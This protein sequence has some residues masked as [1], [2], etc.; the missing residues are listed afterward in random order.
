MRTG[1]WM[2]L[3]ISAAATAMLAAPSSALA[4]RYASP[5]GL[6]TNDCQSPA[7]A[8]DL[9]TAIAGDGGTNTPSAGE[10]VIVQPGSYTNDATLL[11]GAPNMYIHGDF[12]GQRPVINEPTIG[13][14]QISSGTVSYLDF[15]SGGSNAVNLNGGVMERVLMKGAGNGNL[16]CQCY[17]GILRDSV[18]VS[19][20]PSGAL[21]VVSNGGT[22]VGTY[23]NVT[24]VTTN[25]AAPAILI[26][27]GGTPNALTFD[28]Y[29][30][31]ASNLAGGT[32]VEAL[33]NGAQLTL[34]HSNYLRPVQMSSGVVQDAPG[35]P[36]QSTPPLFTNAAA[37][38]FSEALGSPTI[39]A[40]LTDPLNGGLDFAGDARTVGTGT[41]IGAFEFNPPA[42]SAGGPAVPPGS[43]PSATKSKCKK[44]KA[45]SAKKRKKCRKKKKRS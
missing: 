25:P 18:I 24:A 15:E 38:D 4:L 23:R 43:P 20:G 19:S 34:H 11:P 40:G 45:R 7:T 41:D 3:L 32:D 33:G 21:G 26:L 42:P 1:L 31:I 5:T 8:C 22:A 17:G 10:E 13:Q 16:V 14:L 9:A 28:A 39:D 36:H 27:Q 37:F 35:D 29:N 44:K 12:A 30:V 6:S 2:K